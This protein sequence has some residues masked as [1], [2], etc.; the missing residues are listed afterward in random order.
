MLPGG[1]A[2]LIIAADGTVTRARAFDGYRADLDMNTLAGTSIFPCVQ[3]PERLCRTIDL[4]LETSRAVT[5]RVPLRG[6]AIDRIV[7]L[8][9]GGQMG[10]PHVI[11]TV[12]RDNKEGSWAM[13]MKT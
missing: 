1:Y 2:V 4:V 5:I 11:A 7:R 12:Y 9:P 6:Y 8:E 10:G 3:D 13:S